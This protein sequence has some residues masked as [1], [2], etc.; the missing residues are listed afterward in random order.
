MNTTA[1]D[2]IEKLESLYYLL[3]DEGFSSRS[4]EI[5]NLIYALEKNDD[6]V[7]KENYSSRNIW[8]GSGSVLDIDFRNS[9]KNK[10]R[11]DALKAL[12]EYRN[13]VYK[14]FWRF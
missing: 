3:R 4:D 14:P 7:F 1:K 8:G 6:K 5:K 13:K 10:I 11:D 12:K 2:I 9:E